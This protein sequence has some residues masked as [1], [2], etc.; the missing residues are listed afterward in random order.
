MC[1]DGYELNE[2]GVCSFVEL[3]A[4]GTSSPLVSSKY[5]DK[6]KN[7]TETDPLPNV[8]KADPA[9]KKDTTAASS[10]NETS[11]DGDRNSGAITSSAVVTLPTKSSVSQVSSLSVVFSNENVESANLPGEKVVDVLTVVGNSSPSSSERPTNSIVVE[12]NL[13][14]LN[15][16][17]ITSTSAPV[18]T[19]TPVTHSTTSGRGN[20]ATSTSEE[21]LLDVTS[22]GR[23]A[24]W[25]RKS[26]SIVPS[27][28][29][30]SSVTTNVAATES[31]FNSG[32]GNSTDAPK[33]LSNENSTG[34]HD[35]T[36]SLTNGSRELQKTSA[37]PVNSVGE[38]MTSKI[39]ASGEPTRPISG[40][41]IGT[42]STPATTEK[43]IDESTIPSELTSTMTGTVKPAV[44]STTKSPRTTLKPTYELLT[45]KVTSE[46]PMKIRSST[47]MTRYIDDSNNETLTPVVSTTKQ[48]SPK[49]K[50]TATTTTMLA[51]GENFANESPTKSKISSVFSET[52][53]DIESSDWD[54]TTTTEA[55]MLASATDRPTL[56]GD[57]KNSESSFTMPVT[58]ADPTVGDVMKRMTDFE[59]MEETIKVI[60]SDG[61][62]TKIKTISKPATNTVYISSTTAPT[63]KVGAVLSTDQFASEESR[64]TKI[65][66]SNGTS[67]DNEITQTTS[68]TRSTVDPGTKTART[69]ESLVKSTSTEASSATTSGN[70]ATVSSTIERATEGVS[71]NLGSTEGST[72]ATDSKAATEP[73]SP[74]LETVSSMMKSTTEVS[75]VRTADLPATVKITSTAHSTETTTEP[76]PSLV[77]TNEPSVAS[78][79]EGTFLNIGKTTNKSSGAPS[80]SAFTTV[81]ITTTV[82]TRERL[83]TKGA[84]KSSQ[85]KTT[86]ETFPSLVDVI[87]KPSPLPKE[88]ANEFFPPL[89]ETT[90]KNTILKSTAQP[91][92]AKTTTEPFPSL[93]DVISKPSPLPKETATEFFPPLGETTHKNTI[94]KSTARPSIA[95]TT[96]EPF[97]PLVDATSKP[98]PLPK[99][100]ATEFFPPLGETTH[101]NTI[102]KSTARPSIAKT[103]TEPFPPLVDATSKPSPL[104]K[105]TATEFFPPLG[106]T[107]HKNTIL[108]S[109][110]QPS[111]TKTTTEPFPPLVDVTFKPSPLPKETATEFFPPLGETTHKNTILKSTARP[112]IAKTTTEPFPPLV[113][114]TFKPSPLPKE[115]ATEFFP[116]LGETTHKNTILK[117][118]ARPSIA[119]TTTEPL[120]PLVDVTFKPSPLPKETATE[121]FPPLGETTHKNTILKS[122]AQP[123]ITKTTTEPFPPLV[124][125]TFKPSPLPKETATEFFPPLGETT[126]KNT[127]LK[128]TARPSIA[129]TTTEPFPPLVDVT[130]KPS[131]LPK[132]TATE[133]FPPLGETTHKNTI[134]KS[135]ARPSIAKTTTEPFPPLVD[136]TFKPSP[137]PKETATEFFPPLG[138]TTHKNTILKSTA[139]PSIAKTT[140]EPLPP[141]VDV[142]FKPSPLPKETA[143]EFFPPL[144]ETTHKNTILKS[145]AQPSIA[146][147]TTEPFP[148]LVD[149]TSEPSPLPKETATEFFP[150]LGETT[151]KN[152]IL[153]STAQPSIAKTTTEPFPPLVDVTSK[154]S[155]LP[156]ETATEFFPPLG[157]TTHKNTIL[158]STAQ[159]SIA[160]TTTE[161]FPPLMENIAATTAYT[162]AEYTTEKTTAMSSTSGVM[163]EEEARIA[164][165]NLPKGGS[166]IIAYCIIFKQ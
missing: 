145:T 141:L 21:S 93:V 144:G 6:M 53:S 44:M 159:P 57:K 157:E 119:K 99:E 54:D 56:S 135:T 122:T 43:V 68:V 73:F 142:T 64:T 17:Q 148:P 147:T 36:I 79:A 69:S 126:H 118:T 50:T 108:K 76:F 3:N 116:P 140:T 114:V 33:K 155:P 134:L 77:D 83:T 7:F 125:V 5:L 27:T 25:T 124:D 113:D 75:K 110:A 55:I 86:T 132:E 29:E 101:K 63:S 14:R 153:E 8:A 138:E 151:H 104:P 16:S 100:T 146:K 9:G 111:I 112:S 65:T 133:F 109:T 92:I 96:T 30:P 156:K 38:S 40:P 84:A 90:H 117:S 32:A 11:L 82:S 137:L 115:T 49:E 150:P 87:S 158:K 1:C 165:G 31:L 106:E 67:V 10:W 81:R 15:S 102:L 78:V 59:A 128:S 34:K 161:P 127:I 41:T 91:S 94:L 121:F 37:A 47:T 35:S 12:A 103:T 85:A 42:L 70:T 18:L 160:K 130:F 105:E 152:T 123:S 39:T 66:F 131:P 48:T 162:E 164:F 26:G 136:V 4:K 60:P 28:T 74:L 88:T 154:P 20:G 46:F 89:G 72:D 58:N 71:R 23:V 120:P 45:K 52:D 163:S 107:T 2:T 19:Y 97:P 95:K 166:C 143:T 62:S 51:S 98:S 139:Q 129:K 13:T 80:T 149:V 24:P 22:V 61:N